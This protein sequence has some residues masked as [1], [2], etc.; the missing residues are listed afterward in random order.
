MGPPCHPRCSRSHA[1]RPSARGDFAPGG[2]F[3]VGSDRADRPVLSDCWTRAPASNPC[4][5]ATTRA[6][7]ASPMPSPPRRGVRRQDRAK[8]PRAPPTDSP[9]SALISKFDRLPRYKWSGRSLGPP[10]PCRDFMGVAPTESI[11]REDQRE[12]R[13]APPGGKPATHRRR[14]PRIVLG[15]CLAGKSSGAC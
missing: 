3:S 12:R 10:M 9:K 7:C 13:S 1:N 15:P 4:S 6:R 8:P 2:F 5:P 11:G 14:A